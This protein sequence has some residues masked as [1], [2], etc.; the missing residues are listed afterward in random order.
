MKG[1]THAGFCNYSSRDR[2]EKRRGF[3]G[4]S[5]KND[6]QSVLCWERE[7]LEVETCIIDERDNNSLRKSGT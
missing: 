2:L 5:V 7:N 3:R 4:D 1:E 6:K